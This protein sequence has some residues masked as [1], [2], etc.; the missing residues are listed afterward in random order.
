VEQGLKE[1]EGLLSEAAGGIE[2]VRAELER[3]VAGLE[4]H[5]AYEEEQLL[6]ALRGDVG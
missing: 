5:F 2:S 1:F 6:P 4:Q 3:V